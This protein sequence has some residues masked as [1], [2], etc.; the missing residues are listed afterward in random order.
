MSSQE[1]GAAG[2]R[3]LEPEQ[4]CRRRTQRE[5]RASSTTPEEG[6]GSAQVTAG[7]AFGL[8][9]CDIKYT[10]IHVQL[11]AAKPL[12]PGLAAPVGLRAGTGR[13]TYGERQRVRARLGGAGPP[14]KAFPPC[15][16]SCAAESGPERGPV[17]AAVGR[18]RRSP[19]RTR[20]RLSPV[21]GGPA[22][23]SA[24]GAGSWPR[25]VRALPLSCPGRA[26]R[27]ARPAPLAPA[28]RPGPRSF[29]AGARGRRC[30][31]DG[32]AGGAAAGG[33]VRVGREGARAGERGAGSEQKRRRPGR[34]GGGGCRGQE[35]NAG[36]AA[37]GRPARCRGSYP[38]SCQALGRRSRH[39]AAAPGTPPPLLPAHGRSPQR[40]G[41][42][43]LAASAG[44]M[45]VEDHGGQKG[46]RHRSGLVLCPSRGSLGCSEGFLVSVPCSASKH[47]GW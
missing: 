22:L 44:G 46:F 18:R 10:D 8:R 38:A 40:V 9:V 5:G 12:R 42:L 33:R 1:P 20:G 28:P 29:P 15:S 39:T 16:G 19:P 30:D 13:G 47:K 4:E 41:P 37:P 2:W 34:P 35:R 32:R 21:V 31:A 7:K 24:A 45:D 17:A 36:A 14:R 11:Q 43:P 3:G 6:E 27:G 26:S 25:W 23:G